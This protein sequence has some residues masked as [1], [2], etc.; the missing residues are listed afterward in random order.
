[1][2]MTATNTI[3][4]TA[5]TGATTAA[6]ALTALPQHTHTH[7]HAC[8]MGQHFGAQ[9]NRLTHVPYMQD[10]GSL[11]LLCLLVVLA[12]AFKICAD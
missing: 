11:S 5:A 6:V 4:S 10:C 12:V 8:H 9:S 1:M 7:T 2:M 3:P